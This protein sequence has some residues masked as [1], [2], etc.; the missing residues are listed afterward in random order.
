MEPQL[1][2]AR[3]HSKTQ[4][5]QKNY[6]P[7]QNP[8]HPKKLQAQPKPNPAKKIPSPTK[9]QS[10]QKNSK[11]N[12]NPIQPKK[13]QAQPKPIPVQKSPSPTKTQARLKKTRAQ[14]LRRQNPS[15]PCKCKNNRTQPNT[16]HAEKNRTQP[17][18]F[19]SISTSI[20]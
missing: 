8:I 7:N 20:A 15:Q 5:S 4:S 19:I 13:F 2:F 12:Q 17:N 9:T 16:A 1:A 6:K 3:L 14:K 11:P 18:H 10:S